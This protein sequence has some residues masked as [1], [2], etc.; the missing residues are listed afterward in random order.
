MLKTIHSY[1]TAMAVVHK[2][3]PINSLGTWKSSGLFTSKSKE[4]TFCKEN[5]KNLRTVFVR[6][7]KS[8]PSG[9]ARKSKRPYYLNEHL[10]F[11]LPYVKPSIDLTTS[12]NLP[13]PTPDHDILCLF[14]ELIIALSL[15]NFLNFFKL[16]NN[17]Y[18]TG[19]LQS[20]AMYLTC[21]RFYD[22]LPISSEL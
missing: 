12:G 17:D 16:I 5:W 11:L 2:L 7:I 10:Q 9:S 3:S 21:Q 14:I 8:A 22:L 13:S 18:A 1:S 19:P 6:T 4:V 15:C 20:V